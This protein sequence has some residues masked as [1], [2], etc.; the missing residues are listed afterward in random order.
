[1]NKRNTAFF[2]S[3]NK[4]NPV[5]LYY[6]LQPFLTSHTNSRNFSGRTNTETNISNNLVKSKKWNLSEM[7]DIKKKIKFSG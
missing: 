5:N 7:I 2:T 3:G 4:R 1:M 6:N